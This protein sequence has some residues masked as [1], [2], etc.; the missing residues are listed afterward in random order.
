MTVKI[1]VPTSSSLPLTEGSG[2]FARCGGGERGADHARLVGE[3]R[4]P[5]LGGRAQQWREFAEALTHGTTEDEHIRPQQLVQ[6][7]QVLIDARDP[8]GEVEAGNGTRLRRGPFLRVH[9]P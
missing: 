5:Y 2:A 3:K 7:I 8:A 4:R 9:A 1:V 6:R